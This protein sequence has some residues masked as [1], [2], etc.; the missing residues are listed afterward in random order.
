MID[1]RDIPDAVVWHEGLLLA[2]Q[3][4]QETERRHRRLAALQA[5][6][7][8]AD[9]WGVLDLSIDRRLLADGVFRIDRLDAILPDGLVIA[10]PRDDAASLELGVDDA[11]FAETGELAVHLTVARSRRA[12]EDGENRYHSRDDAPVADLHAGDN[13]VPVARLVPVPRLALTASPRVAPPRRF[14]SLPLARLARRDER[15]ELLPFTPPV[16]RL[17]ET[18]PAFALARET[19]TQLRERAVMWSELLSRGGADADGGRRVSWHTV[20]AVH[21]GLPRLEALVAAGAPKPRELFLALADVVG[22]LAGLD[23][24]P[25][26]P[27]LP[28]YVHH[29]PLPAFAAA[30][31]TIKRILDRLRAPYRAVPFAAGQDGFRLIPEAAWL[32]GEL[33]VGVRAPTASAPA[34]AASWFRNAVVAPASARDHVR[35]RRTLG[36]ERRPVANVPALDLEPPRDTTLFV[37]SDPDGVL[38]AD[39]PLEVWLVHPPGDAVPPRELVLYLPVEP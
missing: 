36:L 23:G 12:G 2:P 8:D 39:E 17:A 16:P 24:E 31:E 30:G 20:R 6:A 38:V 11:A 10:H 33:V 32:T 18:D 25:C 9:G 4:F 21:A 35:N 5:Q 22:Q 37:V 13:E 19:A 27:A 29:D 34:A 3:H 1:P 28:S 14:V 7:A 15:V 26:P